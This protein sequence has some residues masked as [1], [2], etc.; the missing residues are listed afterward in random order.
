M[1]NDS[2]LCHGLAIMILMLTLSDADAHDVKYADVD[3]EMTGHLS[4]D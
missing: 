3:C 1:C 2:S 4:M